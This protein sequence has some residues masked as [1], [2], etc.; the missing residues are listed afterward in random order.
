M[1]AGTKNKPDTFSAIKKFSKQS[2]EVYLVQGK[3]G[4]I[5]VWRYIFVETLKLPLFEKAL[6]TG[7]IVPN[8]YGKLLYFG[9][10]VSPSR[11]IEEKVAA[12][13]K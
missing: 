4:E 11:E 10:G 1:N 5:F 2:G 12:E 6:K 3:I 8:E 7:T 13:Y 9:N